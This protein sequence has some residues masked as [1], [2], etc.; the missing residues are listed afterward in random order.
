MVYFSGFARKINH[1]PFLRAKRA[2]VYRTFKKSISIHGNNCYTT[3]P[4]RA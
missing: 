4:Y 2:I 3:T 1:L